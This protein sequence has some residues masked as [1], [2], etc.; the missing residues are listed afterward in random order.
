MGSGS[1]E[2]IYWIFTN[3][4]YTCHTF[5]IAVTITHK[6]LLKPSTL[7][8]LNCFER[9]FTTDC[10]RPWLSPI[11]SRY[12]PRTENTAPILLRGEDRIENTATSIVARR[13]RMDSWMFLRRRCIETEILLLL[14]TY[15]FLNHCL[16]M[17]IHDTISFNIFPLF[18][19]IFALLL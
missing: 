6:Q 7:Q 4:S 17:D 5:E 3:R 10:K 18:L 13:H 1:D 14:P 9:R 2:S 19:Y 16:A 12:G 11:N 8:L 15:S